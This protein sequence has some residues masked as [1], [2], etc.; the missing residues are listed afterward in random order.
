MKPTFEQFLDEL[1]E[2]I[3][4]GK[5]R[6][7]SHRLQAFPLRNLPREHRTR[8]CH[9]ARRLRLV[10]LA[11]KVLNPVVRPT[12]RKVVE[13][14][15]KEKAEYAAALAAAG[16]TDE[17]IGIFRT[18]DP[19][20]NVELL[21]LEANAHFAKW[22]YGAALP[23]LEKYVKAPGLADYWRLVGQVNLAAAQ[24]FERHPDA[25]ATLQKVL[26]KADPATYRI[27]RGYALQLHAEKAVWLKNWDEARE[28]L[29][30]ADDFFKDSHSLESLFIKKWFAIVKL[31]EK[32]AKTAGAD[33]AAVKAEAR[34]RAHWE[35]LRS[36]DYHVAIVT[37]DPE[38]VAHF[39]FGT[40]FVA[41]RERL[42]R[43][44][45]SPVAVPTEYRWNLEGGK[46]TGKP[47]VLS[48][49]ALGEE[50]GGLKGGM[51]LHR[52][53]AVLT[54]DFYR[55]LRIPEIH[56]RLFVGEYFNPTSSPHRI[57]QLMNRLRTYFRGKRIPIH[58]E[59]K[60]SAYRL[61][62]SR[63]CA[64]TLGSPMRTAEVLPTVRYGRLR[65][66]LGAEPF[67]VREAA[68]VLSLSLRSAS[69]ALQQAVNDGALVRE[70]KGKKTRYRCA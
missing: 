20:A 47:H 46:G 33:L 34:E 64:L 8:F 65:D 18:L 22:D 55:P 21:L 36:V 40:P 52:L 54:T 67:D 28:H 42:L 19:T 27:L 58:I 50:K 49:E 59:E 66:V 41:L 53:L 11:L 38:L 57:A 29:A 2:L 60:E 16:A 13:A 30:V 61:L 17:A 14:T 68:Q 63:P 5:G 6:E 10:S 23:L 35:T 56:A 44:M 12:T 37:R 24:V 45:A 7:A 62:A 31:Y 39:I 32:G 1:D 25:E 3:R 9:T 51:A 69:R 70:G 26:E 4:A 48:L 43:D 15:D